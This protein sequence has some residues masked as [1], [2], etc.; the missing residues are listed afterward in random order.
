MKFISAIHKVLII[1]TLLLFSCDEKEI[2]KEVPLDFAS[3]ENSFISIGDFNSAINSL[4][5]L[6]RG[7]LSSGEF[8][9]L[10]YVYGTDIG[11]NGAQQLNERFGSYPA[12][13][14]PISEVALFHWQQYYKIISSA[15]IILNRMQKSSLSQTEK[16]AVEAETRL[17]RGLAYRNLAHLYGGVPIELEEVS[18]PKTN[19]TR[20][21]RE[22][23]YQQAATD[24][25]FAAANL[26]NINQVKDGKVSVQAANHLLAESYV[27]LKRYDD[28]VKAAT[29]VITNSNLALMKQRFGSLA[30][31]PGDVYW[32]LFRRYNQN[33][34]AG[35]TEGIWVFQYEVDVLGGVVRS[36]ALAGPM[37]E[38]DHAPRPYSFTYKDPTGVY[39]FLQLAVSDYTGGRGIGRLRGT[40]HLNYGIW[41]DDWNDMRNSEYNFV[42]DVKFNNPA[43]VW[44]GKKLS[45]FRATFRKT[46]DDTIRNFYPYQSKV[47][48]PGQHPA[49]LF[50]DPVLKTLNGSAAGTTYSDQYFIRLAETY[51]LRAEAH[52]GKGDLASAAADINVVRARANAKP[53][54]A[55]SVTIEYILD[56][57]MRELGVE[58]KR[59]LTLN[60]LGL[61]YER[62]RKY[63][64]GHPTAAKFGV[65]VEPHNNLFPIPYSEIERNTGAV[66]EQNPGYAKR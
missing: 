23:V 45:E 44:Y 18:S 31:E 51:L 22:Q 24:L 6:T 65:D 21:S 49:E 47:T 13:L 53:V 46:L 7:T 41:K 33:R 29:A 12:T 11:Y 20:S 54:A 1:F 19:Y 40:N 61:L 8:R 14:T 26:P 50:I 10:D 48:T 59:R 5:D 37:L 30:K 34:S 28:A 43:S 3:P 25:E 9:P 58:E 2:L 52:L 27:C 57:R 39:P 38:R 56:E 32:D 63:C 15:N 62:T 35:N 17:F 42:R 60:R 16:T 66:L 4:Y 55:G 64:N 36:S